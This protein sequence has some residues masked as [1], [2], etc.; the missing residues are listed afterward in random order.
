VLDST[1]AAV[2]LADSKGDIIEWNARAETIFGWTRTE[3]IGR[4]LA[5]TIIPSPYRDAHRRGMARFV[6]AGEGVVLNRLVEM[7]GLRRDGT[8]FPAEL[9]ISPLTSGDTVTFCGFITDI[10]ERKRGELASAQLA[11]IVSSSDDAIVGTGL[12]GIIES[13]NAGAERL[14]GYSAGEMRGRS[15]APLIPFEGPEEEANMLERIG[16]GEGVQHF[17]G[18]RQA[19]D[20]RLIN[21]SVAISPIKDSTGKIVGASKVLR[22]ITERKRAE[23][24]LRVSSKEIVELKAALDEH[25]IVAITDDRGIITYVND[26]F[27]E[28]S[29]Y[30]REEL[31][32]QDHRLIN[33]GHHPKEFIRELWGTIAHGRVWHG[34]LKNKAK[35]G[36]FY[37]VDTTIVPFL[38]EA[39]KPRQYVAVR[40]DITKHKAAESEILRLNTALEE[41]V[42][43]RTTE[44]ET[45]NRE[46]E[47]F[48]Y[49]ISHDLRAP[50]RAVNG[51]ADIALEDFG[52]QLPEACRSLLVRVRDRG[53]LMGQLIDDLLEFSRLSQ[54]SL[55]RQPVNVTALVHAV[56]DELTPQSEGR[57]MDVQVGELPECLADPAL[58]KQIWVNLLSNAIKYTR[59]QELAIVEVGCVREKGENVF[60]VRDNGVGFDMQYANKL[61]G[62]FHRLHRDEEFEGTGVGLAIVQRIV[63]RHGGRVWAEAELD[64]GAT[65][66]FTLEEVGGP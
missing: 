21:V 17:E 58:A 18:I 12:D 49:S 35:D 40:A 19:K 56:L 59:D 8:Q 7:T 50:L 32:G 33:S 23:E 60:F 34:E 10:T 44:L 42:A 6:A 24:Q 25:A 2:V 54:Q 22:D 31:L 13:W 29:R 38:N 51:F 4:E 16:R 45:A 46:L 26:K 36:S 15:V 52:S 62:V 64:R 37:W 5:D 57:Q 1:F 3:A 30:P 65:F 53:R 43:K 9:F 27:C 41:R 14:F 39:G 61:F 20:R 63:H 11:A 55:R 47:A 48:S 66:H 28:I